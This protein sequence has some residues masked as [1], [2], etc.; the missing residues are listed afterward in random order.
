M[1]GLFVFAVVLV[2]VRQCAYH[3]YGKLLFVTFRYRRTLA[4]YRI[5]LLYGMVWNESSMWVFFVGRFCRIMRARIILAI[6]W[7]LWNWFFGQGFFFFD[8]HCFHYRNSNINWMANG[9]WSCV[10]V[11]VCIYSQ[12]IKLAKSST[13]LHLLAGLVST[14][15]PYAAPNSQPFRALL[16]MFWICPQ[17]QL[18]TKSFAG[19]AHTRK[20]MKPF[21]S[22]ECG[23]EWEKREQQAKVLLYR[24]LGEKHW[25]FHLLTLRV[26]LAIH[27]CIYMFGDG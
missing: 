25:L 15:S 8:V 2:T 14:I 16:E 10:C 6:D 24:W 5:I 20:Q 3:W 17:P 21:E 26:R 4:A 13:L 12:F 19:S 18:L 23:V 7:P 9:H 11:C 27:A 22:S 1:C